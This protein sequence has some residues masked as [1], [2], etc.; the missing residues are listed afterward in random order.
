VARRRSQRLQERFGSEYEH[1]LAGVEQ[2]RGGGGWPSL[3]RRRARDRAPDPDARE[4]YAQSWQQVQAD[5][6]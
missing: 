2:A 6:A 1:T 3:R 5:F 4:R